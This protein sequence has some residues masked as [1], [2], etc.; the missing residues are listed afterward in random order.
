[1]T[2][3]DLEHIFRFQT[4]ATEDYTPT[5]EVEFHLIDG[6]SKLFKKHDAKDLASLLPMLDNF[7]FD[8]YR[9]KTPVFVKPEVI[10]PL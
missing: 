1:M 2:L 4:T 9:D 8:A 5:G 6:Y 10:V 3:S 7:I